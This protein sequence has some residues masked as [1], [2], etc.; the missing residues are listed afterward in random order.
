MYFHSIDKLVHTVTFAILA[1]FIQIKW[2]NDVLAGWR[3]TGGRAAV[4]MCAIIH[5]KWVSQC[6]WWCLLISK[7]VR[8]IITCRV[9][10][11]MSLI[12]TIII[13]IL[14]LL[15]TSISH[16]CRL[17]VLSR[18]SGLHRFKPLSASINCWWSTINIVPMHKREVERSDIQIAMQGV[19]HLSSNYRSS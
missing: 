5:L 6:W 1:C 8:Q 12:L 10:M 18:Q 13:I 9:V 7:R 17:P 16:H 4:C 19:A 3:A 2:K 14:P 11:A 15:S